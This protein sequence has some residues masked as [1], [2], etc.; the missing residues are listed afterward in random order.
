MRKKEQKKS[1]GADPKNG[2]KVNVPGE[3]IPAE[4]N[5]LSE[6]ELKGVDMNNENRGIELSEKEKTGKKNKEAEQDDLNSS[7]SRKVTNK[8]G[9]ILNKH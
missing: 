7:K 8:G 2:R 6:E 3:Q 9:K 4:I 5:D 1:S